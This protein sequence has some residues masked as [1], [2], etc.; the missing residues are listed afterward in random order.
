M[1]L[2]TLMAPSGLKT[3]SSSHSEVLWCDFKVIL[4]VKKAQ[5][6]FFLCQYA[7][8]FYII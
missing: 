3:F 8:Q 5:Q 2:A 6:S 4:W 7:P 1:D